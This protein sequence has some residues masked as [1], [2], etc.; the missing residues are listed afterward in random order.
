MIASK[1]DAPAFLRGPLPTSA[2]CLRHLPRFG[3][4]VLI[5]RCGFFNLWRRCRP[6]GFSR[7]AGAAKWRD[8]GCGLSLAPALLANA[9]LRQARQGGLRCDLLPPGKFAASLL[10]EA[11]ATF[12]IRGADAAVGGGAPMPAA[13]FHAE[14][15]DGLWLDEKLGGGNPRPAA[16]TDAN[17]SWFSLEAGSEGR[18]LRLRFGTPFLDLDLTAALRVVDRDGPIL[19]LA[20]V[21]A[22]TVLY[23]PEPEGGLP[24]GLLSA[25]EEARRH[26]R[27]SSAG[28][29]VGPRFHL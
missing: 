5:F 19:R 14:P 29:P 11:D 27:C 21:G 26:A 6:E 13:A 20:D 17:A 28:S 4:A 2:P 18:S 23:L 9:P 25:P 15:E 8:A 16:S 7:V 3:E 10:Y 24:Q 12:G 22:S 1:S